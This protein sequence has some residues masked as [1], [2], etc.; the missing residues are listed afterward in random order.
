MKLI[1]KK[2]RFFADYEEELKEMY[3]GTKWTKLID[4]CW[5][6]FVMFN[7]FLGINKKIIRMTEFKF[8]GA[9]DELVLDHCK[10]N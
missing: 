5:A 9:K 4:L 6:Q 8:E 1:T 3:L 7:R 10:K 2:T